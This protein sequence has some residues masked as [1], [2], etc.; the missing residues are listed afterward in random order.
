M[1]AAVADSTP[2]PAI[3]RRTIKRRAAGTQQG[4]ITQ[5]GTT[6]RIKAA[7]NTPRI[8]IMQARPAGMQ[9]ERVVTAQEQARDVRRRATVAMRERD[10]QRAAVETM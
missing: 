3:R 6:T 4:T 10:V 9:R 7:D 2:K 8:P 1:R 5:Q